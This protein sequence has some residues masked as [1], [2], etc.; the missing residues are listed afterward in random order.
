MIVNCIFKG[1]PKYSAARIIDI[2]VIIIE[3][4]SVQ[5]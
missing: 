3:F 1:N 5:F 4:S 2:F